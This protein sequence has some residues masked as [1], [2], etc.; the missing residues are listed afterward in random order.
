MAES[1]KVFLYGNHGKL[2]YGIRQYVIDDESGLSELPT[3]VHIGSSCLVIDTG[4]I[5]VINSEGEWVK[6]STANNSSSGDGSGSEEDPSGAEE[7]DEIISFQD[8]IGSVKK[9]AAEN[10]ADELTKILP[11]LNIG[12]E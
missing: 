6:V 7:N 2:V 8:G 5:Y 10:G 9:Y 1:T 12:K 4:D 3:D 11:F